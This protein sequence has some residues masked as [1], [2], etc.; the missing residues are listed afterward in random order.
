M[1]KI[2]TLLIIFLLVNTVVFAA[3]KTEQPYSKN[4]V[5]LNL[6]KEPSVFDKEKYTQKDNDSLKLNYS[7]NLNEKTDGSA[8][9]AV[10]KYQ[11]DKFVF[12]NEYNQIKE[13][14]TLNTINNES[15][16]VAPEIEVNRHL[17]VKNANPQGLSTEQEK[18]DVVMTIKPFK[19]KRLDLDVGTE[20]AFSIDNQPAKAQVNSA[21]KFKF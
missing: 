14:N 21:I 3:K 1:K 20:Q 7:T 12:S 18:S 19:D 8:N 6:D 11:K 10:S 4:Q 16:S 9:D 17:S 15:M 5:V 2:F 13:E